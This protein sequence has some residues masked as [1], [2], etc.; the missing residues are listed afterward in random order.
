L[1]GVLSLIFLSYFVANGDKVDFVGRKITHIDCD[2]IPKYKAKLQK[3]S[4]LIF[5]DAIN[6]N[7]AKKMFVLKN[8]LLYTKTSHQCKNILLLMR[9]IKTNRTYQNCYSMQTD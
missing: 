5:E 8:A 2:D 9:S 7:A 3:K 4:L 1:R 6:P